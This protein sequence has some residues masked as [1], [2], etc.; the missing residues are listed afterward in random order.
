MRDLLASQIGDEDENLLQYRTEPPR[1]LLTA[2]PDLDWLEELYEEYYEIFLRQA[3]EAA[4]R[5]PAD[6]HA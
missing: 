4:A 1:V 5:F 2:D 3:D 6:L